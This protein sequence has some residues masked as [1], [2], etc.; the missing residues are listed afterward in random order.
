MGAMGALLLQV[1]LLGQ[2]GI[3]TEG[4]LTVFRTGSGEPFLPLALELSVPDLEVE[5]RL[6]FTFGFAT[7]EPELPGTFSDSF[8]VTFEQVD[9][10][11]TALL[12]TSDR[13]GVLWAPLNPG[14]LVLPHGA[15][16]FTEAAF[17]DLAPLFEFKRAYSV[18]Y[19]LPPELAGGPTR[20]WLD[21][22]DNQNAFASLA[23]VRDVRIT[24]LPSTNLP[25]GLKL[26]S[27]PRATGPYTEQ[28]DFQWVPANRTVVLPIEESSRFFRLRS[29][30]RAR[31]LGLRA[32]GR[33]WVL[34]FAFDPVIL[35]LESA[36]DPGGPYA[37]ESA[38]AFDLGSQ[39]VRVPR[40]ADQRFY[41]VRSDARAVI[42]SIREDADGL[43]LHFIF[44]GQSVELLTADTVVGPYLPK[45]VV[46]ADPRLRQLRVMQ[47][48]AMRFFR[49]SADR[50]L[51]VTRLQI[52]DRKVV[53]NYE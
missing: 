5:P 27:A 9:H 33:D 31:I 16:S 6:T 51:R 20:L 11:A 1:S 39:T 10:R 40:V 3:V 2:G 30:L 28:P 22:F 36:E 32:E 12:L 8:S 48:G 35:A 46:A 43:L 17:A 37:V 24:T 13:T 41:R 38:A 29:S 42:E 53:L 21:L 50:T 45:V 15:I 34:R 47:G 23:Y 49:L 26:F 14:G 7:A 4:S 52:A 18:S 44:P 25:S 19:T